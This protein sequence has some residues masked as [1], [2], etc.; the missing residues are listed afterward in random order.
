MTWD[1][2][3]EDSIS[4][5]K[6]EIRYK[7]ETGKNVH[8]I[9]D[10]PKTPAGYR[11]VFLTRAAKYIISQIK[12]L[13]QSGDYIFVKNGKRIKGYLFTRKL[14]RICNKLGLRQRSLHKARKTYATKLIDASVPDSMIENQMGH[15]DIET[16]KR[17][18]YYNSHSKEEVK[19][20]IDRALNA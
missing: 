9:R 15:E 4:I 11:C 2:I 20:A 6:T 16:T 17:Y 12:E 10:I 3:P 19:S 13:N 7:D 8:A 18:Y 14:Y 5:T 1:D